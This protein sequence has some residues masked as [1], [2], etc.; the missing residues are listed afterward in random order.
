MLSAKATRL[1]L[2]GATRR[3]TDAAVKAGKALL[4]LYE[5]MLDEAPSIAPSA[6]LALD[7][8][9]SEAIELPPAA[10]SDGAASAAGGV[11]H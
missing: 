11:V 4:A 6:P 1:T 10:A 9:S 3:L 2:C 7:A 8:P 5:I